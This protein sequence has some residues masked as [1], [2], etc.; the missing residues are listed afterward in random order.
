MKRKRTNK[1]LQIKIGDRFGRLTVTEIITTGDMKQ[2]R[3]YAKCQCDCGSD[4]VLVRLDGLIKPPTSSRK[5]SMSCGCLQREICTTHGCW[6]NPLFKIWS[7][8]MD[9]CYRPTN[10]RYNRYGGRGI[11]VCDRWHD[12][13]NFIE[14]MSPNYIKGLQIDRIDNDKG[15]FLENCRWVTKIEQANNKSNNIF[16]TFND[17]TQTLKQWSRELHIVYGTLVNRIKN[18]WPTE[19]AFTQSVREGNYRRKQNPQ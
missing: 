5:P 12:V 13:N 8:M 4:S 17:K 9:R 7:A 15:Y 19:K 14:D 16:I 1:S 11:T 3:R 10:K 6:G 2:K 18:G